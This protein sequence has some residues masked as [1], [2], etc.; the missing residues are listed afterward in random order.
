[1]PAI[2]RTA[3]RRSSRCTRLSLP[4]IPPVFAYALKIDAKC[5]VFW[6]AS[7]RHPYLTTMRFFDFLR[8]E[9]PPLIEQALADMQ[10]M[11]ETSLSMFEDAAAFFLENEILEVNLVVQDQTVNRKETDI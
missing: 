10:V 4:R 5:D 11:L 6:A 3:S 1:M 8:G 2:S 7:S 9:R